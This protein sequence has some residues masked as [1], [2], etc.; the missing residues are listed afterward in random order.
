MHRQERVPGSELEE[1]VLVASNVKHFLVALVQLV[2][3]RSWYST[4]YPWSSA[5]ECANNF[6]L[7]G[8]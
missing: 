7:F 5:C 4:E 6:L 8:T 3:D 2:P 1:P